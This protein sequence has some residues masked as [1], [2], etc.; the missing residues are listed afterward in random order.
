MKRFFL[1]PVTALLFN[2]NVFSQGCSF[3][4]TYS[5]FDST[6]SAAFSYA[7]SIWTYYLN[8][9]VPIKINAMYFTYPGGPLAI[10]FSN[11]RKDFTGAAYDSTWYPTSLANAITGVEQNPGEVDMDIY[12]NGAFSWYFGIDG[13]TPGSQYDFVSVILHEI[14]H[15][16]GFTS[17]AKKDTTMG[18]VG[19][20]EM[21]DF[22]PVVTS[23]PWPDLDTLPGVFDKFIENSP[24]TIL[25]SYQN[26]S[27]AL[28]SQL[29]NNSQYFNGP[30]TL[31][32]NGG[33]R[34]RLYAP[35]TFQLGTSI[36]HLNEG[37]Y[38]VG[39]AEELMTPFITPGNSH[40][41]VGPMT[42][43]ML[44]DMGWVKYIGINE[45]EK[46]APVWNMWPNPASDYII[47]QL[48]KGEKEIMLTDIS[49][50]LIENYTTSALTE[51]VCVNNL[52]NGFYSVSVRQTD[53]YKSRKLIITH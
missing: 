40:H 19:L 10:T 50:Q 6:Q 11:G 2:A 47:L 34:A 12:V 8:S 36:L 29:T 22:D 46:S 16:L 26:P 52:P 49:G 32:A 27:T 14:G 20:L 17:L 44:E 24:G 13:V 38:P 25:L 28:G 7:A 35:A 45:Q 9:A 30:N 21:S 48:P 39:H 5:G 31:A 41:S 37:S 15:G 42:M 33:N 51:R 1:I 18:S 43:G 53:V 4:I 3:N 23:F